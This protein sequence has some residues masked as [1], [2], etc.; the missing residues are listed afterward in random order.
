MNNKN[1]WEKYL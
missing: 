1:D